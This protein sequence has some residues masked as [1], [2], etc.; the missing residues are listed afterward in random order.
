[1]QPVR[2]SNLSHPESLTE[3][4]S[5]SFASGSDAQSDRM[6]LLENLLH[7]TWT[8]DKAII[9]VR[10]LPCIIIDP[11]LAPSNAGRSSMQ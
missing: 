8:S 7:M 5:T 9:F 4:I 10:I 6:N 3:G 11:D 2:F 1:M